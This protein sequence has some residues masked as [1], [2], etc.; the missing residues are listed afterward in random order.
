MVYFIVDVWSI[1]HGFPSFFLF[2]SVRH[3]NSGNLHGTQ[4]N[5]KFRRYKGVKLAALCP[6]EGG[7]ARAR[8][9]T[10]RRIA[11][12]THALISTM[13]AKIVRTVQRER[14]RN[15]R[16]GPSRSLF[17][18]LLSILYHSQVEIRGENIT[19][20]QE[21]NG[22][23]LVLI[24]EDNFIHCREICKILTPK[25]VISLRFKVGESFLKN[26]GN[27]SGTRLTLHYLK[28]PGKGCG[29]F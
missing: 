25:R 3:S 26:D 28:W 6:E 7:R 27:W 19:I 23:S 20:F 11:K 10:R 15:V 14:R 8:T 16:R 29:F 24:Q 21:R 18:V 17:F 22:L 4:A 1:S 13:Q 2:L 9:R 5:E 12:F